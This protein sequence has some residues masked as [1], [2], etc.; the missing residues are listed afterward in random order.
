MSVMEHVSFGWAPRR[1]LVILFAAFWL[2]SACGQPERPL[3]PKS[4]T[5]AELR[6]VRRAVAVTPPGQKERPPY[7]RER[8]VDGEKV[9]VEAG[10]LAWLR[11][12]GGA[13]LLVR[14][15]AALT[16]YANSIELESGR[17]FV[18][19]P[20]G[21]ATELATPLGKLQLAR[22]RASLDVSDAGTEAYVLDGEVRVSDAVRVR[23]GERL[24]AQKG[25]TPKVE[26]TR[27]WQDWTGGLATTDRSA[28]PAPFGVGTVGARPPGDVG[29]PRFPLAIQRMDVKVSVDGE[30]AVTEVD[31]RFFNSSS[32]KVEGIYR[33][34][35][36]EG[37][38]IQRFGVD[39]VG[40]IAWGRVKESAAAAEQYQ[41]NVYEGSTEDPALLE[42]EG[43]GTYRARLYPIGPGESRRVV[44]RY[45]EWLP[46][47]GEKGERRHYVYPMAA[48]G[49]EASIPLIEELTV[50]IELARA[51]ANEV[52]VGMAG[53]RKGGD[54]VVRAQ[55]FVPRADLSVEFF[56]DGISS[57]SA[58]RSKHRPDQEVLAP[59]A[60]ADA[61]KAALGEADYVLVPVRS[62]HVPGAD[63]AGLDLAIVV[64]ASAANDDATMALARAAALGL[65]SHLG[66]DDRAVVWAGADALRPVVAGA[67]ALGAV[68]A[69][70]RQRYSAALATLERGGATDLGTMLTEAARVLDPKR[71]SAIVY[72]GDGRATVG[73]LSLKTLE[74]RLSKLPRPPRVFALGA[75]RDVDMGL[76][77][78][79]STGG[80]AERVEDA[81]AA[82]RAAIEVLEVAERPA[83]IGTEVDLGAN[84]ERVYPRD[85]RAI[86]ADE[87]VLVVGR[88]KGA[89]PSKV[90][91]RSQGGEQKELPLKA[92]DLEDYGDLRR[93]WAGSRLTELIQT[94]AGR[95]AMV[96]LGSRF[97]IVTPV[98]SFY[99]PTKAELDLEDKALQRQLEREREERETEVVEESADNKE[100][101]TGT[102]AK[103]AEGSMGSP[104]SAS[105]KRYAVKGP[106]DNQDPHIA[107]QQAVRD[108]AEFG[109]IGLLNTG[110]GGGAAPTASAV[111]APPAAQPAAN[112][113]KSPASTTTD[114]LSQKGNT[115][116]DQIGEA[117]GAGGLGLSGIGE[118]GGGKSDG[119]GLGSIGTLGHG[120]G[121]GTGQ[122][123]GSGHGRLGGA[124]KSGA[125]TVRMGATEVSGRL[126]PEV[127]QRI[128]RQNHGRFR[129]CYEQGLTQNPNL[130]GRVGVR[131]VIDRQ[132][133]VS[134]V[135]NAGSDLPDSGVVSCIMSGFYGLSFPQPEGG[136]VTV[137]YPLLFAPGAGKPEVQPST[138]PPVI[139]ALDVLPRVIVIC[140]AAAD[141]PLAERLLL[142][143]ERLGRVAGNAGSVL[144]VYQRALS[145][146]EAPGWAE[147]SRLLSLM[148]DAL[149]S[150][151]GRV[152]LW[153]FMKGD[154][155]VADAL[156]RGIVAR[157]KT[158]EEMRALHKSLGL[159]SMDPGLLEKLVKETKNPA[160]L[161]AKLRALVRDWP[162]DF[163]LSLRLLDAL[164]DGEDFAGARD[165]AERMRARPDLDARVRTMIGELY[166]RIS[167]HEKNAARK[168]ED[169]AT[170]RR[171]FGEI[172]EFS[173]DDPVARRRLGDLL[174]AHGWFADAR[175]QYETL[176]ELAPDDA[177]VPLLIA[178]AANGEGQ[179]E[180][181][182]RWTEKGK[183][184]GAPDA[185]QG[186]AATAR[187]FAAAFLAWG[188]LS[189]REGKRDKELK[190]LDARASHVL[191]SERAK[192]KGSVRVMLTW[193]HP[194]L[195]PM[196]ITNALGAAMPA[197]EGD[198]TLGI[199]QARLPVKSGTFVEV[200]VEA[201][202]LESAA[203]L[204]AEAVLTV[205]FDE[206]GKDE[207]IVRLPVKFERAGPNVIRFTIGEREVTRD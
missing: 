207:K 68:D 116:G 85:M 147:R 149:P 91:I 98:T 37:A 153:R 16:L 52:R 51:R 151:E 97:G 14:G 150:V 110:A 26:G 123:F 169:L 28:A 93:R 65:L 125:P 34:R 104:S 142:W 22:V 121:T 4:Q 6:T 41:S 167:V 184:A 95:A 156:Y 1:A 90:V 3:A 18:D 39:R 186:P 54:I 192:S 198:V 158:V 70:L 173:P 100:G 144:G 185:D 176:A 205:V 160:D 12:D 75:G 201:D 166:L 96:D 102:R 131:F 118:G 81:H 119:L 177:S 99:V 114:T 174:R 94:N 182:V 87:T 126:P 146:C 200:K 61:N 78:G 113:P 132:G 140:S 129:L 5:W 25:G 161:A 23:A 84:V 92:S 58:Y 106:A 172:V 180:A 21:P 43:P 59:D 50:R 148:L 170:A 171:V 15:P 66:S 115:W 193:S 117:K 107:R 105:N 27:V 195:H 101:G 45:T 206:L 108:S 17:V 80:F 64:D 139:L 134:N 57:L 163:R 141:L 194:E 8:L 137:T 128:V 71:R 11:R 88:A 74:Q 79:I 7:P 30:F 135:M 155:R 10:G 111:A 48:E 69:S 181:A 77:S 120:A 143:R 32:Q 190:D 82:A 2:L 164:E 145:G 175:R 60:R 76:L 24:T 9:K 183:G 49:S 47:T 40:N 133:A 72:I 73:E 199:A 53:T 63:Q 55:D 162:D 13:T 29:A 109:M 124:H 154:R 86:L 159:K 188:R 44:V 187:A 202:E 31:Q 20:S 138:S 42:W 197:P 152:M 33:F 191:A 122:G 168:A 127:V 165:F 130:Q 178:Q 204:G 203:R 103:G 67:T 196:L 38:S 19:T 89:L 35:A 83:W 157:V 179:L 56:D 46:R 36:P 136:I 62:H 189:A 112:E